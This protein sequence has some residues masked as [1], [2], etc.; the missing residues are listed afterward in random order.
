MNPEDEQA[1][2]MAKLQQAKLMMGGAGPNPMAPA[3]QPGMA[4][5]EQDFS[6]PSYKGISAQPTAANTLAQ[7]LAGWQRGR[8]MQQDKPQGKPGMPQGSPWADALRRAG[9]MGMGAL[10]HPIQS[11]QNFMR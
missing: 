8:S 7:A 4:P 2:I 9:K 3:P 10:E 6:M 1:A 11:F 5:A